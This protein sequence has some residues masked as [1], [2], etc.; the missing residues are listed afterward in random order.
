MAEPFM[1]SN[2]GAL[3]FGFLLKWL[4]A[5]QAC[6]FFVEA[7]R[8]GALETLL[9]TPLT[10]RDL[11]SGQALALKRTFLWPVVTFLALLFVPA[12]TQVLIAPTW[13][14]PELLSAFIP[15]VSACFSC[16][17]MVADCYALGAFGMW[18]ALTIKKPGLA[19]ALTIL[20]V[21][22]LPSFLCGLGVFADVFFIVWGT[23]KLSGQDL[24]ALI[25]RQY[26]PVFAGTAPAPSPA[27]RGLPPII[28]K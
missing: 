23:S 8:T 4:F 21:L 6:R 11:I 2:Y 25:A 17:T 15:F 19:P 1:L 16:L 28:A 22:V 18:L 7:R 9:C 27:T 14:G 10:S 12:A 13:S 20:Y 24:R 3:P 5:L 26:Q